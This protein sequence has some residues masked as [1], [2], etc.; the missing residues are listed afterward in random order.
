M[1]AFVN[2]E[3]YNVVGT[4]DTVAAARSDYIKKI[5]AADTAEITA[6]IQEISSAVVDGDTQY[7]FRLE[8]QEAVYVASIDVSP[9]LPFCKVGDTITLSYGGGDD[10]LREVTE[11]QTVQTGGA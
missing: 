10:A 5:G 2:V 9:L 6:V 8:G 11:L 3:S 7:Y 4:G 1:Y